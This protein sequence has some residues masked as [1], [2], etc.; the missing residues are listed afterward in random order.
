MLELTTVNGFRRMVRLDQITKIA[1][2]P[3]SKRSSTVVS[4]EN[5]E[6]VFASNNYNEVKQMYE[7]HFI[8]KQEPTSVA[9][10]ISHNINH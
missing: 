4:L 10:E 5:G 1:E 9:P 7:M 6:T 2:L 3:D 8:E